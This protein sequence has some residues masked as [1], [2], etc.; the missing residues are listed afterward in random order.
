M[1][2]HAWFVA[3]IA[4]Q[5]DRRVGR[6]DLE[7]RRGRLARE[8]LGQR[9]RVDDAPHN[10]VVGIGRCADELARAGLVEQRAGR[11]DVARV[12]GRAELAEGRAGLIQR[13]HGKRA[14]ASARGDAAERQLAERRLIAFAEQVAHRRALRQVVIALGGA[15]RRRGHD[16][17]H[18][19][20]LAPGAWR[21][22]RIHVAGGAV[23]T[24]LG[25]GVLVLPERARRRRS[26]TRG[27]GRLAGRQARPR[28]RLPASQPARSRRDVR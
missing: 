25:L 21:G 2:H 8:Q 22:A 1:R 10:G 14:G 4:H 9:G 18:A 17:S 20:V 15:A 3:S 24:L 5:H 12:A 27:P 13:P 19:E 7:Q 26:G 23:E 16:A 11:F 28:W 6:G